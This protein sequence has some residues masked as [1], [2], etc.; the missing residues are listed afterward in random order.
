MD[1]RKHCQSCSM[2]LNNKEDLGTEKDGSKNNQYCKYCYVNGEFTNPGM[3]LDEMRMLIMDR[4]KKEKIPE[5]I[6]EAAVTSLPHL[7]RWK[8]EVRI[9][10]SNIENG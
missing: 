1:N 3:S 6:I 5:D 4:M 7:R 2:P 10:K 9:A 8:T